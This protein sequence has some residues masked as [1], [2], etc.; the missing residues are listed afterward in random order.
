MVA[1][2]RCKLCRPGGVVGTDQAKQRP[3]R[4]RRRLRRAKR[5]RK[6]A[7]QSR[8]TDIEHAGPCDCSGGD[9]VE[10]SVMGYV[11]E[12]DAVRHRVLRLFH[13]NDMAGGVERGDNVLA[14]GDPAAGFEPLLATVAAAPVLEGNRR[15]DDDGTER[16]GRQN[17]GE[18]RTGVAAQQA[19]DLE[20][21]QPSR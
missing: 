19:V 3:R 21:A 7:G 6:S 2:D 15:G 9:G 5:P 13:G 18:F 8:C 16:H 1:A 10:F 11:P 14:G 20:K 17:G 4:Q 12:A